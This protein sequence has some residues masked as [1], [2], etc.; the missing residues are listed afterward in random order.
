MMSSDLNVPYLLPAGSCRVLYTA[1][2]VLSLQRSSRPT[3][4]TNNMRDALQTEILA[5]GAVAAFTVDVL[6]YPLDTIKTRYQSQGSYSVPNQLSSAARAPYAAVRSLYQGIGSVVLATLPAG[7]S[8]SQI[9]EM[10]CL[11]VCAGEL[12]S[13]STPTAALFFASYESGKS[14]LPHVLPRATPVAAIHAFASAGAEV[15]SC[16]VLTPAEVIKLNAQVLRRSAGSPHRRSSS[17]EAF[18]MLRRAEGGV[19]RTLWRGYTSLVTRNLPFTAMQFPMFE[20]FRGWIANRQHHRRTG[21]HS[22]PLLVETGLVNGLAA[23]VSGSVAAI[24]TTPMDVV[25]TRIMLGAG[26]TSS[27]SRGH[28]KSKI[29]GGLNVMR[30]VLLESGIRGLF[31]GAALRAIWTALGSGLYL[32]S[33]EVTKVWLKRRSP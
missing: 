1:P 32:G 23:A 18:D 20:F 15:A 2:R 10:E 7:E 13:P 30:A 19:I 25:K 27:T 33:Y 9:P 29:S 26:D 3:Y 6:V 16:L 24:L 8:L 11:F 22:H 14:A 31:R 12:T 28:G 5:A 4:T 17:L 21:S